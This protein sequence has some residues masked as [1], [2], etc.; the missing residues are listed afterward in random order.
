MKFTAWVT[1]TFYGLSDVFSMVTP[2]QI[3]DTV[4]GGIII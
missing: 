4:I 1:T 3:A 2:L